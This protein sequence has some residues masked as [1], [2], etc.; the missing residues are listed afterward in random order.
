MQR[1]LL[2]GTTRA[3]AVHLKAGLIRLKPSTPAP[4]DP[5]GLRLATG[6]SSQPHLSRQSSDPR[7]SPSPGLRSSLHLRSERCRSDSPSSTCPCVAYL[8]DKGSPRPGEDLF[9]Q[10]ETGELSPLAYCLSNRS[11]LRP[12]KDTERQTAASSVERDKNEDGNNWGGKSLLTRLVAVNLRGLPAD[13]MFVKT[14]ADMEAD[15]GE[16]QTCD[17]PARQNR[18]DGW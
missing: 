13:E 4:P 15:W 8:I 1:L 12:G 11:A 6:F 18:L 17:F 7:G 10:P 2:P 14:S 5:G 3:P 16:E 9:L